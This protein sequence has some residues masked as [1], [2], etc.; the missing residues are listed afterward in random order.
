M[1]NNQQFCI[2]EKWAIVLA[3]ALKFFV[4]RVLFSSRSKSKEVESFEKS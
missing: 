4:V 2:D 1:Q 3:H